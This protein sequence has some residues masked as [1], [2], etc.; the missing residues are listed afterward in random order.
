M[1]GFFEAFN[2]KPKKAPQKK[3]QEKIWIYIY[4]QMS[5]MDYKKLDKEAKL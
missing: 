2:S 5:T 1:Q 4:S 3:T